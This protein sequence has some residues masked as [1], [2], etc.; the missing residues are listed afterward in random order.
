MTLLRWLGLSPRRLLG[1]VAPARRR[2]RERGRVSLSLETLEDRTLLTTIIVNP[3]S[4]IQAAVNG[5]SP[6]DTILVN[7]GTYT[8]QV[9][10]NK[11]LTLQGN[12]AGAIIQSPSTLTPDAFGL[13]VLLEVNNAATVSINN[14]TIQGP[15]P[16]I[17]DGILVV[18]DAT[19]NV[20][21]STIADIHQD[22][23]TFGD[24]TGFAIQVGGTGAQAVGQVGHATITDCTVTDYQK[25]GIIIGRNGS[26]G[27]VTGSTITGIGPTTLIAQNGIQIG[28]GATTATVSNNTISGNEFTG[29]G[30]G[31][32]PTTAIQAAGIL[33]FIDAGSITGN[34]VSN[35]DLGIANT[36]TGSASAGTTIGGNTVQNN[37]FE[38]ILLGAGTATVS[39]NT[40][41][42]N[43]IGVAVVALAGNTSDSQGTLVS[44]NITNNGKGGLAFPGGGIVL[45]DQTGATTAARVTANFNRIV[46]NSAGLNNETSTSVDAT[47]NWW[48]SN[49]G[50]GGAGSDTVSGPVNFSP[51]LVLQVTASPTSVLPGGVVTVVADLTK[52]SSGMDTSALGHVPNGIPVS[53]TTTAGTLAPTTGFTA[54][55]QFVVQLTAPNTPG[56]VT[57]SATVDNQ[58]STAT[59]TVTPLSPPSPSPSKLQEALHLFVDSAFLG[60]FL[61][62]SF[63]GLFDPLVTNLK[64]QIRSNPLTGTTLGTLVFLAGFNTG[65]T[66]LQQQL[67]PP[68]PPHGDC[69]D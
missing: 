12:G 14:M 22:N 27:T 45:L 24:Q 59:V 54:A 16:T 39:N 17:N 37:R 5:A 56:A 7:P 35:N 55:G 9:T 32:D 40:I 41:A 4:S 67:Q 36:N 69:D 47:N 31:P 34:T 28:P 52:N 29:T 30:S 60:F 46:G 10:I 2:P 68:P 42:G 25:V 15:N 62:F 26:S 65:L 6:G 33:N 64:G 3:G 38:G 1:P 49:A 19:A 51:W 61:P 66:A 50:P 21:E 57:V 63:F 43:N 44:N 11:N 53:F 48:G 8:E 20:S 13:D 23:A 58:T 18:G